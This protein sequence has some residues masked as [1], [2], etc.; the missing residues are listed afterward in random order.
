M[1]VYTYSE[2]RQNFASLLEQAR[3]EGAVRIRRRD[4]QS[5]LLQAEAPTGSPLDVESVDLDLSRN[6]IVSFVREGRRDFR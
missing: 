2:A 1:K 6:E 4:G 5:F 3:R